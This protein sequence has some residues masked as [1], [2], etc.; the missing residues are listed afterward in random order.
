MRSRPTALAVNQQH[1][2]DYDGD[3][4]TDWALVRNTGGGPGGQL[5]W[6]IQQNLN[7]SNGPIT[8]QVFGSQGD[9]FVPNDY[10]GDSKT[11]IAI[12]RPSE[13]NWYIL[14]SQ[15]STLRAEQFGISTDDPSIVGDYD[16]DGKADLA[17]Y[18]GGA[19]AGSTEHLVLACNRRRTG[20]RAHLGPERRLPG[21]GRL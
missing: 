11:D 5:T 16:G 18:R 17:V 21:T 8:Y 13:T 3:G 20:L 12:W 6:F 1:V 15:T 19:S 14:Q 4:K 7:G 10:D 2:S 9:E